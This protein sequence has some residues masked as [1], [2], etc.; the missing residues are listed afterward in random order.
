MQ[1]PKSIIHLWL[2]SLECDA[3]QLDAWHSLLSPDEKQRAER[4]C[5][6]PHRHAFITA[7]AQ[8]R[9]VLGMYLNM[10]PQVITFKYGAHKKPYVDA[11]IQFNLS[12]SHERLYLAISDQHQVGIDTEYVRIKKF[13]ALIKRYFSTD[14]QAYLATLPVD[15]RIN[16]FFRIWVGKEA[17]LKGMG[18][19][20]TLPLSGFSIPAMHNHFKIALGDRDW[21]MSLFHLEPNYPVAVASAEKVEAIDCWYWQAQKKEYLTSIH[22]SS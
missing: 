12:H 20:L 3:T 9:E 1:I 18:V 11:P 15:A 21:F 22:T 8:L 10:H 6:L 19:G 14:E 2:A 13:A 5:F 17:L 4:F 7:R 16:A